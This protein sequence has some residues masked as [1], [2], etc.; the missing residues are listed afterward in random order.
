[1]TARENLTLD[2]IFPLLALLIAVSCPAFAS[3]QIAVRGDTVY[4]MA[5]PPIADGVVLVQDGVIERVGP[6]S[7]VDIPDAYEVM[8][9]AIVTPGLID[10][11]TVVG[12]AGYL[13]Q[14]HDQDQVER[15]N[16]IQ[17]ELRAIDAYNP[18]ERLVEWVRS[19]GITTVHTGHGPGILMSGQT[20]IVKTY[21][22]TVEEA[23]VDPE[24]MVAVTLG[25]AARESQNKSPGTRSKMIAMLRTELL[26][27]QSY[28]ET[29][30]S[31]EEDQKPSRDLKMEALASVLRGDLKLLVSVDRAHDILTTIRLAEEFGLPLILDSAAE[32]YLVLEEIKEAGIPIIIHPT[33]YR[34]GG[35]RE[36][37]SMTTAAKLKE[38]DIPFALQSGFEAYVPK[39][40]VVLFE[41]GLAAAHGLSFEDAL[42]SITIDAASIL[43]IDDRVGSLEAGKDADMALYDG[44]P[45]EYTTHCTGVIINGEVVSQEVR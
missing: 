11:H 40:R 14:P 13:N 8:E 22:E 4:T 36:N 27:A 30:E 19:F 38:A 24:T 18:R 35:D 5:G 28:V 23:L 37:L 3:A 15:S 33:M 32:A 39:T 44:D 12:I 34:A 10:A 31:A 20:M 21:G 17:P 45:F 26:K 16:P 7:Q 25:N 6:A 29:L 2:R 43:G 1:M 42:A 9:A 41:A